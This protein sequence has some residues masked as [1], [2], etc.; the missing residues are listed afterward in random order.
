MG[1]CSDGA[2]IVSGLPACLLLIFRTENCIYSYFLSSLPP[3]PLFPLSSLFLFNAYDRDAEDWED[4][5]T[6]KPKK[7]PRRSSNR[8]KEKI[9]DVVITAAKSP[10]GKATPPVAAEQRTLRTKPSHSPNASPR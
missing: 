10:R 3:L 9:A 2:C 1:R 8:E 5:E 7:S 6:P 4:D